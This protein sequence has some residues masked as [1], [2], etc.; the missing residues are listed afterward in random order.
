MGLP[1]SRSRKRKL[2]PATPA[3]LG[4]LTKLDGSGSPEDE[5]GAS[6]KGG[7]GA[8]AQLR[9]RNGHRPARI[10]RQTQFFGC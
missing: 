9:G 7:R 2:L 4:K 6:G 3:L 10:R 5:D 1:V 8:L